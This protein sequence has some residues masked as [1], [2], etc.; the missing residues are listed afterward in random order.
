MVWMGRGDLLGR[1]EGGLEPGDVIA[2]RYRLVRH[3]ARGGMGDVF[4]AF[5]VAGEMKRVALK[6]VRAEHAADPEWRAR[7]K[8]EV[9]IAADIRSPHV[10][11]LLEAGKTQG[12]CRWV[13]IEYLEGETLAARLDRERVVPFADLAWMVD[14]ALIG[15]EAAHRLGIVHRDVKPSNLFLGRPGPKLYVLDFGVARRIAAATSGL[16]SV[17]DTIGTPSYMSPEQLVNPTAVD[18]RSDLFSVGVVAYHALTGKLP[19]R[20]G[21][22][23][24]TRPPLLAHETGQTWAEDCDLWFQHMMARRPGDRFDSASAA[25]VVWTRAVDAVRLDPPRPLAERYIH[26]DTDLAPLPDV[27]DGVQDHAPGARSRPTGGRS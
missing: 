27:A 26:E 24:R 23:K 3:I 22:T 13:A 25:R 16:T 6:V 12:G 10:P 11:R 8:R 9:A 14:H 18:A 1:T 20:S 7:F 15:L 21:A 17:D 4:E 5:P 2:G 19:F